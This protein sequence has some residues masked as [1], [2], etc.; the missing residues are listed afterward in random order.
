MADFGEFVTLQTLDVV[1]ASRAPHTV[2]EP[3]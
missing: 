3:G 2:R 1:P